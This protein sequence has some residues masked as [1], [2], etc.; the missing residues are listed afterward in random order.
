M[1]PGGSRCWYF[2]DMEESVHILINNTADTQSNNNVVASV[3]WNNVI[4]A[5]CAHLG[6]S[7]CKANHCQA[8]VLRNRVWNKWQTHHFIMW[9]CIFLQISSLSKLL[10]C[11]IWRESYIGKLP[12]CLCWIHKNRNQ[13]YYS[14]ENFLIFFLSQAFSPWQ[15]S[16][17]MDDVSPLT[18]RLTDDIGMSQYWYGAQSHLSQGFYSLSGKTSYRQISWSLEAARLDVAMAVSLWN[19]TGTSAAAL[20]RYLSNFRA[21]GDV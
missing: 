9:I 3:W 6:K 8:Q 15:H 11:H 21:I 4:I 1:A 13:Y 14:D 16:F 18:G 5:S 10:Y 7:Q 17:Q 2:I 19:L 20:P 12:K